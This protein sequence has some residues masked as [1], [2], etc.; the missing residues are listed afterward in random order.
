MRTAVISDVHGNRWAL[1]AVMIDIDRRGVDAVLD[2]GDSV[3]GPLDPSGAAALL[4][5]RGVE[6]VCGNEDR[7]VVEPPAE[8]D[9]ATLRFT[10]A[11][12]SPEQLE[13]LRKLPAQ[14]V[15]SGTVFCCH[16]TPTQDHEY[17][18]ERVA[19]GGVTLVA[20]DDLAANLAGVSERVVLCGH[21]H[22]A[23]AVLLPGGRLVV[24]PGSIG[25]PAYSDDAPW[26]HAMEAGSPHARYAILEEMATGRRVEHVAVPY[27]WETAASTAQ[28]NGRPDWAEWLRT[29]RARTTDR[30]R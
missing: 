22:I 20:A 6:S 19:E 3:Y 26:P 18:L 25:L 2:L 4:I 24:N 12:L 16:G 5:A 15:A 8:R 21:S 17:L 1:D 10:R 11:S 14:R 29:G 30:R 28:R 23:R 27:D 9:S 13:W 7:I